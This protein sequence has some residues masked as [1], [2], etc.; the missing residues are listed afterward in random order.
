MQT[1]PTPSRLTPHPSPC[2]PPLDG[3]V[4]SFHVVLPRRS[5]SPRGVVRLAHGPRA[6]GAGRV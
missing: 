2:G 4:D 3:G 5:V 6:G 1:A